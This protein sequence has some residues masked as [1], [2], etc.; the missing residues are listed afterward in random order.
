MLWKPLIPLLLIMLYISP[1]WASSQTIITEGTYIMG[2]GETPA[3]AEE[4]A[5][6]Q[7]KRSAIEQAGTYIESYSKT[8]N[9]ELTEDEVK[10]IAAGG[11]TIS[12]LEKNRSLEPNGALKFTTKIKCD[13]RA[14]DIG[15]LKDRLSDK[16]EL[17]K[18]REQ[19]VEKDKAVRVTK[20][21]LAMTWYFR[22][23][24][25][26]EDDG[27]YNRAIRAY[28]QAAEALPSDADFY[29]IYSHRAFC[30]WLL[31]DFD[32]ADTDCEMV[33]KIDPKAVSDYEA[34]KSLISHR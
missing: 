8:N 16:S 34:L 25:Y 9:F 33:L 26:E 4:K 24:H 3:V 20:F 18:L 2:D 17:V 22:G 6:L 31:R 19:V 15:A 32:K 14:E 11:M 7:A 28:T 30:Y 27:D 13:I 21:N 1:A 23:K 12:I 5:F 10:M 29:F